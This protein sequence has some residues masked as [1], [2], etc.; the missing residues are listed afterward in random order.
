M[1]LAL[2]DGFFT[3]APP[4]KSSYSITTLLNEAV[5]SIVHSLKAY[6]TPVCQAIVLSSGGLAVS[7]TFHAPWGLHSSGNS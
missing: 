7:E 4:G 2:A 6:Q 1:S 5:S 3:T